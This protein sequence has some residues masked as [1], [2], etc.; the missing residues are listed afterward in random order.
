M[1]EA[2]GYAV[3]E[4]GDGTEAMAV[5]SRQQVDVVLTDL[6]MPGMDGTAFIRLVRTTYRPAPIIIAMT[7]SSTPMMAVSD[8]LADELGADVI[9][10]KPLMKQQLI[11]AIRLGGNR[12]TGRK[13]V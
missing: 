10:R 6:H 3:S 8:S 7:G 12:R 5:L 9:L 11:D 13:R 1:L 4:A 2:S